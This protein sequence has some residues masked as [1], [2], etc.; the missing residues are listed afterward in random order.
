MTNG[1]LWNLQPFQRQNQDIAFGDGCR[2]TQE[3]PS[4]NPAAGRRQQAS[5]LGVCPASCPLKGATTVP[6]VSLAP[7]PCPSQMGICPLGHL[8]AQH[9][10][11][12]LGDVHEFAE[13]QELQGLSSLCSSP[14]DTPD[15]GRTQNR[16]RLSNLPDVALKD[17]KH[18]K[19]DVHSLGRS[20]GG[21]EQERKSPVWPS[22]DNVAFRGRS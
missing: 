4:L 21:A 16:E 14:V 17:T 1:V 19:G 22:G 20:L 2:N 8:S 10:I 9:L 3:F 18:D 15:L 5:P 13:L 11:L 7:Q 12:L 6:R